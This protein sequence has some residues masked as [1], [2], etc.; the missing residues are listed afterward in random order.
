MH[1]T[2][3]TRRTI[4]LLAKHPNATA[5]QMAKWLGVSRFTASYLISIF[6]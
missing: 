6:R 5:P 2:N 1:M 3:I 4:Q